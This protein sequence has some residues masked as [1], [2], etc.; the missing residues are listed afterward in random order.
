LPD[1]LEQYLTTDTMQNLEMK[2][3]ADTPDIALNAQTGTLEISG[4]ALVEDARKFFKPVLDWVKE[5][6]KS[7]APVT[8]LN[9]KLEYLN[10]DSSKVIL[11][12]LTALEQ[13]EKSK[14]CW[15]FREDDE[16]MEETGEELA[17]LVKVPFEFKTY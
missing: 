17:E 10:T 1:E 6:A 12:I 8:Q 7:P 2:G 14:V 9:V 16:D 13:V 4:R 5:Y 11:D 15:Y 3:T